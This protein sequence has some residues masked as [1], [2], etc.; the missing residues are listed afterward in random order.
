M[1]AT[2]IQ[3]S[4]LRELLIKRSHYDDDAYVIQWKRSFIPSNSLGA[5]YAL[6]EDVRQ[7][8]T[9]DVDLEVEAFDETHTV[10]PIRRLVSELSAPGVRG[11]VFMVGVQS[12][13]F[14]RAMDIARPFVRA[15][16]P[17]AIGGFHVSGCIAMLPELP[18]DLAEARSL[19]ITLFAGEAEGRMESV[20]RDVAQGQ[21]KPV[22]DFLKDLP[23]LPGAVA[24]FLPLEVADRYMRRFTSIDAGRGCPFQCSFCTIINVQGRKS[25]HRSPDDVERLIRE[26]HARGI[27]RF[28]ITDDNFARNQDWEAILDRIAELREKHGI[29]AKLT[30]QVDTLCHRIPRFIEKSKRAGVNRV[31][32]GLENIN[33]ANLKSAQKHQNKITEYRRMLQ[34]WRAAGVLTYAGYILG[35]PAD[36]PESIARDIEIIKRELPI[37]ILEFFVLTPLPGSEDHQ[38]LHREGVPMDPDMNRYDLEHVNTDHATMSRA[39]LQAVYHDA[40]SRY[41]TPEH[42][43]T[44]LRRAESSGVGAKRA[45]NMVMQFYGSV[46]YERVHPLQS[47][48]FRIK[49]RDSRRSELPS[50]SPL[51]F[52]P[53]RVWEILSTYLPAGLMWARIERLHRRIAREP[54]ARDYLD[55]ATTPVPDHPEAESLEMYEKSPEARAAVAKAKSHSPRPREA[56]A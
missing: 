46:K 35:F 6:V 47:G 33:P 3:K 45:A 14:P 49:R 2:A 15:N 1:K 55:F 12:N 38:R 22:Y 19:G 32:I 5:V 4:S 18:P 24:P 9:L 36:T 37:D 10:L 41:Y 17:V 52:Y 39:E 48:L 7:R 42:I 31:F 27:R 23:D 26:N 53:R 51:I 34:A 28:F 30:L 54:N 21:M 8:G 25:R 40:W 44:I 43:E 29:K 16:V 20:L 50:E 11:V 13:Q 56:T